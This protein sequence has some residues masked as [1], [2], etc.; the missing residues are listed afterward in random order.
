MLSPRFQRSHIS[1][2]CS[3]LNQIRDVTFSHLLVLPGLRCC[4]H[5]LNP[6][7][8]LAVPAAMQGDHAK[9][10]GRRKLERRMVAQNGGDWVK[11]VN[12]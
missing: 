10:N 6:P 8:I 4:R 12:E 7:P 9:L 11:P 3:A 1:S 2:F 5:R